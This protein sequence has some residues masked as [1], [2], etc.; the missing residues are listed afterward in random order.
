MEKP[1]RDVQACAESAER[2]ANLGGGLRQEKKIDAQEKGRGDGRYV[3][4][5][6]YHEVI[7]RHEPHQVTRS[8]LPRVCLVG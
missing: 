4:F 5:G 3:A 2:N 7:N 1:T 6:G 8:N